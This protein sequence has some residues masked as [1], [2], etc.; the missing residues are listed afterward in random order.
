MANAQRMAPWLLMLVLPAAAGALDAKSPSSPSP[1][2]LHASA[3]ITIE[4]DGGISSFAWKDENEDV[5]QVAR[6]VE[7]RVRA[8]QFEPGRIDGVPAVTDTTLRVT[9]RATPDAAGNWAIS[10]A[11]AATG[12][13]VV[14]QLPPTYPIEAARDGIEAEVVSEIEVGADGRAQV[15]ST[16]YESSAKGA[17]GR[18]EFLRASSAAIASWRY[19]PERVGGHPVAGRMRVPITFCLGHRTWCTE[20]Q[21]GQPDAHQ[22]VPLDSRVSLLTRLEA[23]RT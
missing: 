4:P 15:L 16:G 21:A 3:A 13:A 19:E 1:V 12:A 9:L 10:I 20:R 7:P 8:F 17:A 18:R 23:D 11:D 6:L 2:T 22:P 14:S 5:L